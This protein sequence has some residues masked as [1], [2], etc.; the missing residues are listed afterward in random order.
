[1]STPMV[2]LKFDLD[3]IT[4]QTDMLD[5]VIQGAIRSSA[6]AAA[7][8]YYDEMKIRAAQSEKGTGKGLLARSIYQHY[9]KEDSVPGKLAVYHISW[10]KG[11][12]K[13]TPVAPHGNLIEYGWV[14]RYANYMDTTGRWWTAVRPEKMGTPPPKRRAPQAEK[15]AYYV[16]RKN[17]PIQHAP[18]SFLRATYDAKEQ[19]ALRAAQ[20]ELEERI[21]KAFL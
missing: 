7:K 14:Q 12:G 21:M 20:Q 8:V 10:N 18:R 4:S 9:V 6:Q 11:M 1:M 3:G 16:L 15:D 2:S 5:E 13:Q 17:G 19:E